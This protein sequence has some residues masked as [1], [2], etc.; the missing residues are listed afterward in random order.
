M[1]KILLLL[2]LAGCQ[3]PATPPAPACN[4]TGSYT[5]SHV[6]T[7]AHPD[8]PVELTGLAAPLIQ[9][10]QAF[11]GTQVVIEGNFIRLSNHVRRI[12]TYGSSPTHTELVDTGGSLFFVTCSS[13]GKRL[14]IPAVVGLSTLQ[15]IYTG[16][17]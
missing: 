10:L 17:P 11:L 2:L 7:A 14:R 8:T 9:M 1:K 4:P 16:T 15:L 3:K 12:D 5:F 6:A 13:S